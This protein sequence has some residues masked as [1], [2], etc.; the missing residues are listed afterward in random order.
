[1]PRSGASS[2]ERSESFAATAARLVSFLPSLLPPSPLPPL[3]IQHFISFF[4][5]IR[6]VG[7]GFT[8]GKICRPLLKIHRRTG[9]KERGKGMEKNKRK[10]RMEN[11]LGD[12]KRKGKG[13][14]SSAREVSNRIPA[15]HLNMPTESS[16]YSNR[17]G[18]D[19]ATS[20]GNTGFKEET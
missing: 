20:K 8:L 19:D 14:D 4:T 3:N 16:S 1:M 2:A 10:I 12:K 6:V 11:Y 5:Q 9:G 7:T 17:A 18:G 13:V 15:V